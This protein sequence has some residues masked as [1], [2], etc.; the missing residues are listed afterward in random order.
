[1][2]KVGI[3]TFHFARNVGAVL[4]CVAMVEQL[5]KLGMD[6]YVIN[7]R[8]KY[9]TVKY[10]NRRPAVYMALQHM[11]IL[12]KEGKSLF[13]AF[14]VG[15][16]RFVGLL[17][18]NRYAHTRNDK[19]ARFE[20]FISESLPQTRE[21]L[22]IKALQQDP[23]E[24]DA[25][26]SGSDQVWNKPLTN[27]MFDPA[28]FL[29][30]G[31]EDTCRIAYAPSM[32][33]TNI[34]TEK[35]SFL[36]SAKGLDAIYFR[37]Q[38]DAERLE[39]L[40]GKPQYSVKDPTLFLTGKEYEKYERPIP[41]TK[42]YVFVYTV[43]KSSRTAEVARLVSGETGFPIWD[44]SVTGY[45][46][47]DKRTYDPACGPGEFLSYI[48]NAEFVVTNSFH[49]TVFSLLYK[50]NFVTVTNDK[51]NARM[52]DLLTSLGLQDR[53]IYEYNQD[54]VMHMEPI[55]YSAVEEKLT[56][57]RSIDGQRLLHAILKDEVQ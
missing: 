51:R 25:Y 2:K 1:M 5:K 33:E 54:T 7:Y 12:R 6:P 17:L 44:G 23:P 21:Y 35:E 16:K 53:L 36:D 11:R 45:I 14:K 31:S 37:E 18:A 28:Y 8:P 34:L 30:F 24:G 55:D 22:T 39:T 49:G 41:A 46:T 15:I 27:G 4:Q 43:M 32:A 13:T 40:T 38:V 26:I 48:K 9:H 10:R 19:N 20:T 42:P 47:A 50:K 3:I 29:R 56:E 57:S 52:E